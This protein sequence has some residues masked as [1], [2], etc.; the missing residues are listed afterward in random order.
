MIY[1]R[2]HGRG[3]AEAEVERRGS[4]RRRCRGAG[5]WGGASDSPPGRGLGRG[6]YRSQ[7]GDFR[8][9]LDF[10]TVQLFGLNA[11]SIAFRPGQLVVA[12]MQ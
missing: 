6:D 2:G 7:N 11:K 8:C 10:L 3:A 9:I 5:I 4:R 12:C 1:K